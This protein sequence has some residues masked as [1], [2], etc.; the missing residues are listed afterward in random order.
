MAIQLRTTL[1]GYF[2]TG[3]IP[4]E[5]HYIDFIDST[6]SITESNSGN[7]DLEGNISMSGDISASGVTGHHILGGEKIE[8]KGNVTASND[9]SASGVITGKDAEFFGNITASGNIKCGELQLGGEL[10]STNADFTYISGSRLTLGTGE[11]Q[12]SLGGT[13]LTTT[14]AELNYLDGLTSN[15][16]AQILNINSS[17]ISPTQWGYVG[18]MN[19]G[20]ATTDSV[21]F[22]SITLAKTA[23]GSGN[24]GE[25]ITTEGQSFKITINGIPT[26]PGKDDVGK[27]AKTIN[28]GIVNSSI[29]TDSVVMAT[30]EGDLSATVFKVTDGAALFSI[31]NESAT[32]FAGGSA[33]FNFI[34]F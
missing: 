4:V 21:A 22:T 28:N 31:A 5:Q 15:E 19:Q 3:N 29:T 9:I 8:F 24:F 17:T 12:L 1:K 32:T 16:G 18:A 10:A 26:I 7:I 30:S 23:L 11:A 13:I 14:F 33:I 2:Q 27:V 34:I 6:L 20:V 25:N